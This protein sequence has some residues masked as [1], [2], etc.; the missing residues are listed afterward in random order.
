MSGR[1][2]LMAAGLLAGILIGIGGWLPACLLLLWL[3]VKT[4]RNLVIVVSLAILVGLGRGL[5]D[6]QQWRQPPVPQGSI[7]IPAT[8]LKLKEGYASFT[9]RAANGVIVSGRGS[10]NQAVAARLKSNNQPLVLH[11]QH[12]IKRLAPARNQFE[13]DYATYVWQTQQL[14]Y[15]LVKPQLNFESR[16]PQ[17]IAELVDGWRVHLFDY[18]EQLP[19]KVRQYAKGLFLG[20]L[21]EDFLTQRQAFVDLGIFH[22]FSVSGMHLFAIIAG[23]YW[24]AARLRVPQGLV[25]LSLIVLLPL[26]LLLLPL[27]AGLWRAVWMRLAGIVNDHLQLG[28]SGLDLFS[29][30]LM[31]NLFWQPRV[32]LTMGGQLTYLLTGLLVALPAMR[33]WQLNWR[34]VLA[35]M[36]VITWHTFSFNIL[37]V[38][39]NW[40]LMPIFELGVMPGLVI[41]LLL[42][43]ATLTATFDDGLQLLEN[44]L[45]SLSRVPGQIVTGAFPSW[46]ALI[47]IVVMLTVIVAKHW[48]AAACWFVTVFG[49]CWY[50]PNYRVVMFDVG[51]GDAILIETPFHQGAL[52]IDTGGRI[53]GK[54]TNPP[55]R[56]AIVPY[57]HARGYARLDTLLLTHPDMDHV[58]DAPLL[59]Q[60]M[61]VGR[62]ITTATSVQHQMIQKVAKQVQHVQLVAA[63]D[64]LC[65]GPAKFQVVSPKA[66]T[67]GDPTKTNADSIVLYGKIGNSSWLLT[68]DA[69]KEAEEK[70]IMPRQLTADYLKV[71]H[72]GSKTSST[73][74]LINSLH[75]KA[76]L[77]SA[78]VDNRYGH[79][80][81]ETL[82]TLAAANVPWAS[83]S[84][85]GM[86]W[87]EPGQNKQEDQLFGWLPTK[88]QSS[89][90]GP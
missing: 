62:L 51:Q 68:G 76:A 17:N 13:F 56:R 70:N 7:V 9:G 18:F 46:L 4:T 12:Q 87:V 86:L 63:D 66:Q 81:P 41:A 47:G 88:E 22:V 89:N 75:L 48:L 32:L 61:P 39:F 23:L 20:Q 67:S 40:L 37:T 90:A 83:T 31:V 65:I 42:P 58:G 5:I 43:H 77:I 11:G 53:F 19:T 54:T 73:P 14:A 60:L 21:D 28:F 3:L 71:G 74:A 15:E 72:H 1:F 64:W 25:D 8:A 16:S 52:L 24:F 78:G 34:L 44:G 80:H 69:E 59:S 30:V 38:L 84:E 57:L 85:R 29:F 33:S 50:Q 36:P 10:V 6:A 35:S 49:W 26:L 55:V 82:A 2:I 27:G 79:P 45:V